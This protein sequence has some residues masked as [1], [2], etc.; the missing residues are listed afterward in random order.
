MSNAG[1]AGS[2]SVS[3]TC[4]V[5]T[6]VAIEK[7]AEKCGSEEAVKSVVADMFG[8]TDNEETPDCEQVLAGGITDYDL[9]TAERQRRYAMC[10]AW[11]LVNEEGESFRQA[12]NRAWAEVRE[13]DGDVED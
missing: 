4:R 9:S 1:N 5:V 10:R 2:D 12:V 6:D 8:F 11:N 7:A 13:A 3:D